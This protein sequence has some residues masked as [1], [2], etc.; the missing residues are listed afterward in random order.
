MSTPIISVIVPCYN[1]AHF[2]PEALASVQAQTF[3]D[4]ECIIV[5]DGSPDNTSAVAREWVKMDSRFRYI[6]KSNGGRSSTRNRGLLEARG[7]YIQFLDADD[8]IEPAKFAWQENLL[9]SSPNIGIVYSDLRYFPE[10]ATQQRRFTIFDPDE[11]WLEQAWFDPRPLLEKF[12][13]AN[14]LGINC[15]LIRRSVI[16]KVGLFEETLHTMEDWHYW[17]RCAALGTGFQFSP[18]P[19]TLALVRIHPK[20]VTQDM[21]QMRFGAYKMTL[22]VG[23]ILDDPKLR[24]KN[25]NLGMGRMTANKRF[26][27]D[28]Q[29]FR[30]AWANRCLPVARSFVY[31]Y[32][33]CHPRLARM[34]RFRSIAPV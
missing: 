4:W 2:L 26:S 10:T 30:L 27:H 12:L 18:G 17:L 13:N 29:M 1:Q 34:V 23:P 8:L 11:P 21:T 6:E 9:R 28:F 31:A 5:N 7:E 32:L 19:D 22:L 25:F 24:W 3:Q 33:K 16:N 14:I 20:S 15:P